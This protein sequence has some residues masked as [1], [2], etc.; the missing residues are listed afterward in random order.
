M[1]HDPFIRLTKSFSGLAYV[2]HGC[3][4]EGHRCSYRGVARI[5]PWDGGEGRRSDFFREMFTSG[6]QT[7][8]H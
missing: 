5:F 6:R 8:T 4:R 2:Y 7:G 3:C 1:S